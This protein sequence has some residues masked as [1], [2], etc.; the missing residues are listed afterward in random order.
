MTCWCSTTEWLGT[1][2]FGLTVAHKTT[3]AL[4]GLKR[5]ATRRPPSL[6]PQVVKHG[7]GSNYFER[8]DGQIDDIIDA[9]N[10]GDAPAGR[11]AWRRVNAAPQKL[12]RP[13]YLGR[14]QFPGRQ[15]Q[16]A[17]LSQQTRDKGS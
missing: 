12:Y 8:S 7:T 3:Q 1:V 13:Q 2:D 10:E 16:L 4:V 11:C 15:G 6:T 14:N 5:A 17:L 9:A